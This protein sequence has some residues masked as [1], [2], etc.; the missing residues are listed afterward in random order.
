MDVRLFPSGSTDF[1]GGGITLQPQSAEVV[2]EANGSYELQ[3]EYLRDDKYGRH[4][5]LRCGAIIYCDVPSKHIP[6]RHVVTEQGFVTRYVAKGKQ[7]SKVV[8]KRKDITDAEYRNLV[9]DYMR[10]HE[11]V[12]ENTAIIEVGKQLSTSSTTYEYSQVNSYKDIACTDKFKLVANG[13]AINMIEE[14]E[15]CIFGIM[16][17]GSAAYFKL[18]EVTRIGTTMGDVWSIVDEA[19]EARTQ[20]PFRIISITKTDGKTVSVTAQHIYFD[21]GAEMLAPIEANLPLATICERLNANGHITFIAGDGAYISEEFDSDNAVSIV[22]KIC[23]EHDYKLV[24]DGFNAYILPSDT[25]DVRIKVETGKDIVSLSVTE[26][27]SELIT[28]WIPV[29]DDE[30]QEAVESEH[31]NDYPIVYTKRFDA[32]SEA[33]AQQ[34]IDKDIHDGIDIPSISIDVSCKQDALDGISLFD[35]AEVVDKLLDTDITANCNSVTYNAI[36]KHITSAEF[37]QAKKRFTAKVFTSVSGN[38]QLKQ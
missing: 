2:E 6:L 36:T 1:S 17:D 4:K 16:A 24:R 37:G 7:T 23:S 28:K 11:G 21:A 13:T 15:D 18:A 29:I 5:Y 9:D 20:Q 3:M 27:H 10:E 38:W 33:D 25:T 22:S 34:Q 8:T 31:I 30:E 26:D 14:Y 32:E 35:I 12:D 19:S